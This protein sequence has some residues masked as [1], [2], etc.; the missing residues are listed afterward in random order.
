MAKLVA[1]DESALADAA[2]VAFGPDR[3]VV[4]PEPTHPHH[5][6]PHAGASPAHP[7]AGRRLR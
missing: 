5:R 4:V 3:P 1:S 6:R 2:D 7:G